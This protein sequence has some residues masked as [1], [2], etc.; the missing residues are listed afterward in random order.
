MKYSYLVFILLVLAACKQKPEITA[1]EPVVE[2]KEMPYGILGLSVEGVPREQIIFTD[3]DNYGSSPHWILITL[4]VDYPFGKKIKLSFKM[5]QGC[6][7]AADNGF[8]YD[9]KGIEL[10]YEG[11]Y[12]QL[13]VLTP[14]KEIRGQ[15]YINVSPTVPL[16]APSVGHDYELVTDSNGLYVLLPVENW[17][18]NYTISDD[19]KEHQRGGKG[20]LKNKKTGKTIEAYAGFDTFNTK[21]LAVSVPRNIE[22]G[23]YELTLVRNKRTVVVPDKI[24][25][26]YGEPVIRPEDFYSISAFRDSGNVVSYHGYN[27]LEGHSYVLELRNELIGSKR[28]QLSPVDHLT[29]QTRLPLDMPTGAYEADVFIDNK[30]TKYTHVISGAN[31]LFVRTSASQPSISLLSQR[32]QS[33]SSPESGGK[34]Y[35]P[36]TS[37][38]RNEDIIL[39]GESNPHILAKGNQVAKLILKSTVSDSQY[40]L[41]LSDSVAPAVLTYFPQFRITDDV[42]PGRYEARL[43]IRAADEKEARISGLHYKIITIN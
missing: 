41:P 17:G 42:A 10:E 30:A 8:Q 19:F 29:L 1:P 43:S 13:N 20:I 9:P 36:V 34:L 26:K 27:M 16:I 18:T 5:E 12:I 31:L 11:A 39:F 2:E 3:L 38:N 35:R 23:E 33:Y 15:I 40:E 22:A 21:G 25:V 32:S 28:F 6:G 7:L 24:I 37:F 4:P 14:D